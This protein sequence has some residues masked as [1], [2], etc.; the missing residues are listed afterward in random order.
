MARLARRTLWLGLAWMCVAVAGAA[1]LALAHRD[2]LREAFET[3]ARIAHRLLSQRAVQLEA[4]LATLALLQPGAAGGDA[5]PEQRL[6]A[7]YPQVLRVWRRES[8]Q[9]WTGADAGAL[10]DG[11][12][13][14]RA[15]RRVAL[16]S[17]DFAAGRFLLVQAADPASFALQIDLRALVPQAEWPYE[18]NGPVRVALVHEGQTLVLA[19]GH[20]TGS[21]GGAF[22]FRKH[23]AAQ[24]Q[25]FELVAALRPGWAALPWVAIAAWTALS[26]LGAGLLLAALR[27]RAERLRAHALLRLDQVGRLNALGELAAGMAHELNQPLTAMLANAQAAQRLLADVPPDVDAARGAI[28]QSARQARRASDVVGRLR[29]TVARPD[30]GTR[31]QPVDLGDSVRQALELIEPDLRRLGVQPDLKVDAAATS[32][33]AEPVALEQIV[34]NVLTNA[35]QALEQVP[36]D[37][38]RLELGVVRDGLR[39]ALV[40][41]DS[42]PGIAPEALAHL[43]EPFFS[44]RAD[45][46]GLGLSLCETLAASMGGTLTGANSPPRGAEFRL[47]LSLVAH[48][49]TT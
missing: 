41:R 49:A 16:A 5:A 15:A 48:A 43:F 19:D 13:M 20:D 18:A 24:S 14:S 32:V 3:D 9:A 42:G 39:G 31:M 38:R 26:A 25:P 27:M 47:S 22:S 40:V 35:M 2:T 12:A 44:T 17:A 33:Q 45:G 10:A 23:L 30:V 28:E 21:I 37:E 1:W 8:A 7:L 36:P 4:I 34:H 11:E 29:R 46:L 6:P